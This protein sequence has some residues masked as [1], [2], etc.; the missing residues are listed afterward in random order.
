[1]SPA[2]SGHDVDTEAAAYWAK[3]IAAAL[4][5]AAIVQAVAAAY[6][7]AQASG[8]TD[9]ASLAAILAAQGVT[10]LIAA[11]LLQQLAQVHAEG[12]AIG[13]EAAEAAV[14]GGSVD[15]SDWQPGDP[16]ADAVA[17]LVALEMG[18][19]AAAQ[20]MA[21]SRVNA[22]ARKLAAASQNGQVDAAGI[23]RDELSD[24]GDAHQVALTEIVLASSAAAIAVYQ[25]HGVQWHRWVTERDGKVCAICR[26]NA[27]AGPVRVGMPFPSGDLMPPIHPNDRCGTVPAHMPQGGSRG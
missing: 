12:A 7:S 10:T 4:A 14:T 23:A 11:A 13:R 15:W 6:R 21:Q 8:S 24:P 2:W 9:Q 17:G 22:L 3:R 18:E 5:A 1:V 25:R 19:R 27:K 16:P 20:A 26:A